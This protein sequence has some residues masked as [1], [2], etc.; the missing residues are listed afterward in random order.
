MV[1]TAIIVED[2]PVAYRRLKRMLVETFGEEVDV[3]AHFD[4]VQA[5]AEYLHSTP[6]PDI[7]FL[8]IQLSDGSSFD[9]FDMADI[10]SNIIFITAFDQYAIEAFRKNAVD[11]LLKPIKKAELIEAV[12]RGDF[13]KAKAAKAVGAAISPYRERFLIRF[14]SRLFSI[15]TSEIAF[16]YS[17]NKMSFFVQWDGKKVPSDFKLQ[18]LE[19]MLDPASFFRA[20]RQ[21]ILHVDSIAEMNSYS[22]SRIKITVQPPAPFEIIVSTETSRKFKTWLSG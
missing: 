2:E 4:S 12:E 1:M 7:I 11:Y 13:S 21:I 9:L 3:V 16:I 10:E 17:E 6:H 18:D 5:T 20:N 14:G 22:K 19:D 15:K 8:D